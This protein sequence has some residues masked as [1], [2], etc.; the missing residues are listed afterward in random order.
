MDELQNLRKQIDAV[1]EK[2]V[3]LLAKRF[4]LTEQVGI[5]KRSS[6]AP[7]QDRAREAAQFKKLKE[8]AKEA[9]LSTS[10][11]EPIWRAIIDEVIKRHLQIKGDRNGE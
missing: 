7:A 5:L 8:L 6:S 3:A 9:N 4:E 10:V 2:L 1:D 11:V